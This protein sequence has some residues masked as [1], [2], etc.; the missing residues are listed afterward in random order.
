MLLGLRPGHGL[1]CLDAQHRRCRHE[2]PRNELRDGFFGE[3]VT[4][5]FLGREQVEN[6]PGRSPL[7]EGPLHRAVEPGSKGRSR[8]PGTGAEATWT[9]IQEESQAS[10]QE[11]GVGCGARGALCTRRGTCPLPAPV[12]PGHQARQGSGCGPA[13]GQGAWWLHRASGGGVP[14][15]SWWRPGCGLQV[16]D[17]WGGGSEVKTW[18]PKEAR[19]TLGVLWAPAPGRSHPQHT[20]CLLVSGWRCLD[21]SD[22]HI[23]P[24]GGLAGAPRDSDTSRWFGADLGPTRVRG[25]CWQA[26]CLL[27]TTRCSFPSSGPWDT[28]REAPPHPLCKAGNQGSWAGGSGKGP[29]CGHRDGDLPVAPPLREPCLLDSCCFLKK[30]QTFHVKVDSGVGAAGPPPPSQDGRWTQSP[31]NPVRRAGGAVRTAR[32]QPTPRGVAASAEI[33][34]GDLGSAL[35]GQG[36]LRVPLLAFLRSSSPTCPRRPRPHQP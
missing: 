9:G 21:P 36:L 3:K 26:L 35:H 34:T 8:V 20:C 23:T 1:R 7:E 14:D 6:R 18:R 17:L 2:L 30:T 10:V 12:S 25:G 16:R 28:E 11:M 32:A 29:H 4:P 27:L 33:P 31:T 19:A 15:S 24:A 22:R 13:T 5:C